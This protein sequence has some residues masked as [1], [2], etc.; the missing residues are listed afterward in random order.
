[1]PILATVRC[2]FMHGFVFGFLTCR[3][4]GPRG[5]FMATATFD[6]NWECESLSIPNSQETGRM[7]KNNIT[8]T[9][10]NSIAY[11]ETLLSVFGQAT[12]SSGLG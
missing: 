1:M 2:T 11:M 12:K 9:R 6:N 3:G 5:R 7:K 10:R 8:K 4:A